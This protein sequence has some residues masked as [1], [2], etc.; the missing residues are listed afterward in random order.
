MRTWEEALRASLASGSAANVSSLIALIV[1]GKLESDNGV[2]PT[3]A[4]SHW[5]WGDS[6]TRED[7]PSIR[8]TLVGYGIHHAASIFW[9]VFYEKWF[10]QDDD[11]SESQA[12]VEQAAMA[13]LACFVD[14]QLTPKRLTPGFEKRLS[15]KS[16]FFVYTAFGL[17]LGLPRW[18][19]KAKRALSAPGSESRSVRT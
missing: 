5:V 2:A 10:G 8:H 9:A 1:A 3:N 6:A 7:D 11:K 17:G 14:Y 19:R 16:L 12:L 4:I 18:L 13:A 15:K